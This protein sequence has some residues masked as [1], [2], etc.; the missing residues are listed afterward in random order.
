MLE[1]GQFTFYIDLRCPRVRVR[2]SVYVEG[3]KE[4]YFHAA[5]V[6]PN[7]FFL[8]DA[9]KCV[10]PVLCDAM[11]CDARFYQHGQ[12]DQGRRTSAMAAGM[13]EVLPVL[14]GPDLAV[15]QCCLCG[16]R[17]N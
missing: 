6:R 4:A 14:G 8:F 10:R 12:L 11:R 2:G 7:F 1:V 5:G 13:E 17:M 15:R 3:C 9:L 16:H